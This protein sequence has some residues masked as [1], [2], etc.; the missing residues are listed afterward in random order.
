MSLEVKYNYG[1][2][3][4]EELI[5][6]VFCPPNQKDFFVDILLR[7]QQIFTAT[8]YYQIF[9]NIF[10]SLGSSTL[11]ETLPPIASIYF[12]SVTSFML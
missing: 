8:T 7:S 11:R 3:L 6:D 9:I 12:L 2:V 5:Y 4:S 10:L 1:A